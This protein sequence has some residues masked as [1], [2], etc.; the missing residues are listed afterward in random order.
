MAL[1]EWLLDLLVCP[2]CRAAVQLKP[3]GSAL[4]CQACSRVYRIEG[5]IPI[6]LVSEAKIE[7]PA[8]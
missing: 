1:A 4:K 7:G 2:A 8:T 6:M 5:D 3:D